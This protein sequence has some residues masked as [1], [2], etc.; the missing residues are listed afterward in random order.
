MAEGS[1]PLAVEFRCDRKSVGS[2][3]IDMFK[4]GWG[5]ELEI[6]VIDDKAVLL[7]LVKGGLHIDGVPDNDGIGD[8][9]QTGGLDQLLFEVMF[10]DVAFIG[11][12]EK[13]AQGVERFPFVELALDAPAVVFITEIAQDKEGFDEATMVLE[14]AHDEVSAGKG[15]EF[16]NEEGSGDPAEFE[17]AGESE[18]LVPIFFNPVRLEGKFEQASD[19]VAGQFTHPIKSLAAQIPDARGKL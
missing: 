13:A 10:T 3:N 15:L 18:Q 2:V 19:L 17:G 11:D 6:G 14:G 5:D 1:Q 12:E 7:D 9:G 16:G 8:E 4:A